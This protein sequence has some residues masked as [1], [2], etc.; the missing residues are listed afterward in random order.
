MNHQAKFCRQRLKCKHCEKNHPSSL[1]GWSTS[2]AE[3]SEKDTSDVK[4]Q[5]TTDS[6][7]TKN[8]FANKPLKPQIKVDQT[9]DVNETKKTFCGLTSLDSE[10]KVSMILPVYVSTVDNPKKETLVYALIDTQSDSTFVSD[11]TVNKLGL[12]G[13][14]VTL[15]LSTLGCSDQLVHSVK[16]RELLVRGF[17][18]DSACMRLNNVY[19]RESI[20]VNRSHIPTPEKALRWPHLS[21]LESKLMPLSDCDIGLLIGYDHSK[22]IEP[23]EVIPS[24]HDG[25]H[26]QRVALGWGIIGLVSRRIDHNDDYYSHSAVSYNVQCFCKNESDHN[27][28][29]VIKNSC[30]EV[31]S[32]QSILDV[33]KS[34]FN[35]TASDGPT[36]SYNDKQFLRIM[37]DNIKYENNRY[38][39]PLPFKETMPHLPDNSGVAYYRLQSL[40]KKLLKDKNYYDDYCQFMTKLFQN[41]HAEIA[42]IT[43]AHESNSTWFLP[44]HGIYKAGTKKLRI[45]FDASSKCKG[46][47]LNDKLYS[48]PDLTNSLLGVLLRFRKEYVAIMCDIEQMFLQFVV[49][50]SDRKYLQ[51]YWFPD[52]DLSK[53][54][55]I[56]RMRVHCFGTTSSPSCANFALQQLATDFEHLHGPEA[57]SF[58]K[59][60][61]YIDDGVTSTS[62]EKEAIDLITNT[63]K[64]CAHG[65][66]NLHKFLS[67]SMNVMKSVAGSDCSMVNI[68]GGNELE[69]ALGVIWNLE[70]D[71]F[72]YEVNIPEQPLT[73]RG[74]L[75]IV[76]QVYDP[77]GFVGPYLLAGR[78]ILQAA[79]KSSI[80]WDDPLPSE[81]LP[82]HKE[83]LESLK[84]L[85]AVSVNR[86]YKP[87]N[88]STVVSVELHSFSDASLDSYGQCSYLRLVNSEGSIHCSLV[89]AKSRVAP[90]KSVTVPRL[91]LQAALLSLRVAK[92][93]VTELSYNDITEHYWTDSRVVL[94]YISNNEKRYHIFVSNRVDEIREKSEPSSWNYV[95]TSLNPADLAS[96]GMN[97][98][99]V[100][101]HSVWFNGPSF[102][103]GP[104]SVEKSEFEVSPT[105]PEVKKVSA[106]T[107]NS[108]CTSDFKLINYYSN[109][110]MLVKAVTVWLR[111]K[112][113]LLHRV[114]SKITRS[115]SPCGPSLVTEL[116]ES[117]MQILKL[118][119]SE[120]FAS[121]F[122]LLSTFTDP[123][124]R[125]EIRNKFNC[126]KRTSSLY[127]L[128][129]FIDD[130]RVIRVGGRLRNS[131]LPYEQK[132]PIVLPKAKDCHVSLLIIKHCHTLTGH[133]GRGMTINE[134]RSRG[135]WIINCVA[136]V[137][138]F[139]SKCVHCRRNFNPTLSQKMADLPTDRVSVSGPFTHT[140]VDLFGHFYVVNGR[141]RVKRYGVIF[142]CLTSR[143]IH[144]ETVIDLSTDSFI[145]ALR[146]FI[147]IRGTVKVI[148]ADQG[149]NFVGASNEFK[150]AIKNMKVQRVKDSL[151]QYSCDYVHFN[152]NVPSASH[153]GGCWERLIRSVRRIMSGLLTQFSPQ[154]NDEG[155]RTLLCEIM[156]IVN[157]RPLCV[158]TLN[159]VNSCSPLTPNHLLTGK[160]E[161]ILPPPGNFMKEDLYARKIWKRIQYITDQF[162]RDLG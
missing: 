90:I 58:V 86:C 32:P 8:K 28:S 78:K 137:S 50:E 22:A 152:F 127:R 5:K 19:T 142:T 27:S 136:S 3:F 18:P 60:H 6:F 83:W 102:L 135:Y 124:N 39:M 141:K 155:L 143:A 14:S 97:A 94:G 95:N 74:L 24:V 61:F 92:R 64:L 4:S 53:Q 2:K 120:H 109:W 21:C 68:P 25:P 23:L 62:T 89:M 81:L 59:H 54:P 70:L 91:E 116:L 151:I 147:C 130:K 133:Q 17:H 20:P 43:T 148:R 159:D 150:S 160:S 125:V 63:K 100:K 118:V 30:K 144:L 99:Q 73:R 88:F 49:T 103:W 146:R 139:I 117:E 38:V 29:I 84:Y 67:N 12:S 126:L 1:H 35:D 31:L 119:Q 56:Y 72:T 110:F 42:P 156:A 161:V 45:V 79:C 153:F 10:D 76:C 128:N 105:D 129:P 131:E 154:L 113:I 96:R 122:E 82:A 87:S 138:N 48:G 51:F 33:L 36:Y 149:T 69:K 40:K 106:L 65:S 145:N 77:F 104:Y 41:N 112:R 7:A 66:L 80:G 114:R 34:D 46:I 115:Y 11:Y 98:K 71:C 44:H 16:V 52:H 123:D 157:N 101:N 107:C 47:C 9:E 132:Y 13:V 15:S 26:G 134:I 93:I 111:L 140:G 162:W 121:E 85:N 108:K 37:G 57:S 158:D 55:V 75:S